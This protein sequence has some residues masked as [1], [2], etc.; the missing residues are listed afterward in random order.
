MAHYVLILGG[1]QGTRL[2]SKTPKQFLEIQGVPIIMHSAY[3]FL[4]SDSKCK[5]YIGLPQDYVSEWAS[6]KKKYNFNINH[7]FFKGGQKRF[8][9]V[10]LGIQKIIQENQCHKDDIISIHDGARPFIDSIFI[11]QLISDAKI[12][13]SA[14]PVISLKNALRRSE[15]K[16]SVSNLT[17]TNSINR[18]HYKTAQTPQVFKFHLIEKSYEKLYHL[19]FKDGNNASILSNIFDDASVYEHFKNPKE[20]KINE[21]PGREY[22]IKITTPMDYYIAPHIYDFFKNIK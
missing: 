9:T 15:V 18:L 8:E 21:V 7:K 11:S 20:P 12:Y 14:V 1:G 16:S 2:N 4:K 5:I 6:L 17:I 13:G 22:N 19:I 3:A 10:Y